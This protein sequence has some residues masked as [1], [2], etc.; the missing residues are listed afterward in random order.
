MK[1]VVHV[2]GHL[3]VGLVAM[4]IS[5]VALAQV[6]PTWVKDGV[7]WQRYGK[8]LVKP[9]N[10]DDVRVIKPAWAKDDPAD[11]TIAIKDLES[12]QGIFRDVM[13]EVLSANGGYPLVYAEGPD[14]LEVEVELL[15]ITPWVKPGGDKELEGL[16]VTTLGSGE[17]AARVELRDSGNR[18]LL[19]LIEGD[20]AVGQQYTEY[21]RANNI[22][23]VEAMFR[24][25]ATRLRE[26]MDKKHGK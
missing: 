5:S 15:S 10:V 14:V 16:Q 25:F 4:L 12:I 7:D 2:P 3:A 20:K 6:E 26:A 1:S 22:A 24:S 9:L 19:L 23:N 18:E 17:V 8:L 11:W 13:R 21:S